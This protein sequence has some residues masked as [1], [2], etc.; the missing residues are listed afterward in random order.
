MKVIGVG[1]SNMPR[2]STPAD[3]PRFAVHGIIA[4]MQPQHATSDWKMAIARLGPERLG[5]AY[6]WR[7]MLK[8][9]VPLAFGSDVPVEPADPFLGLKAALTRQDA[10]NEPPGGWLPEQKL[11]FT[12]ALRAY[13][14][15]AAYAALPRRNS[16]ISRRGSR[17]TSWSSTATYRPP[18]PADLPGTQVLEVWIGGRRAIEQDA[19]P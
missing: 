15:G 10:H 2:L 18:P 1:V 6:A 13:T 4:S 17:P 3:L 8:N 11:D 19:R 16:A 9:W 14:W 12:E 5:G 7:T